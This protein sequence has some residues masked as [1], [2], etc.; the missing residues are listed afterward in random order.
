M[1]AASSEDQSG[2]VENAS[3]ITLLLVKDREADIELTREALRDGRLLNELL[4]ARDG[5][6]AMR[7]V[8]S[9]GEYATDPRP[10]LVLLDL[11]LPRKDGREVLAEIK[12][13]PEVKTIPVVVLTASVAERDIFAAYERHVNAYITK[14]VDFAQFE[15][16]I[17]S[18]RVLVQRGQAAEEMT[19]EPRRSRPGLRSGRRERRPRSVRGEPPSGP[20]AEG[21]GLR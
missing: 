10:D 2:D 5:E 8:R 1:S 20:P 15:A 13:D 11:N 4:V 6:Q 7:A 12:A 9:E 19:A 18:V 17:H 21:W 3:A 14:P 16:A